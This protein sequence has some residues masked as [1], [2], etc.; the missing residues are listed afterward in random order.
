MWV[1]GFDISTDQ[2]NR[3]ITE[4]KERF[5]MEKDEIL[6]VGLEISSYTNVDATPHGTMARMV[7]ARISVM[8]SLPGLK[9]ATAKAE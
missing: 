1:L 6:R 5:H 3:I 8:R 4:G 9:P 7:I 2:V